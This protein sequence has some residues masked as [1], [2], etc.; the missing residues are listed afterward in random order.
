MQEMKLYKIYK[1][2]LKVYLNFVNKKD[3]EIQHYNKI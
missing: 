3:K 1:G 2:T